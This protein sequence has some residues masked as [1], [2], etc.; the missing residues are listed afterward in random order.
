MVVLV[1]AA[2]AVFSGIAVGMTARWPTAGVVVSFVLVS[3]AAVIVA[4]HPSSRR[5]IDRCADRV[6]ALARRLFSTDSRA[7]LPDAVGVGSAEAHLRRADV[8]VDDESGEIPR[9][10]SDFERSWRRRILSMGHRE[11]DPAALA[12][13]LSIPEREIDL[14]WEAE[15]G[16]LVASVSNERAGQWP[17]RAAF[18]ADVTAVAEFRAKYPEW[19]TLDPPMRTR[20]LAALRLCLD[21]CP[22][23]DGDVTLSRFDADRFDTGR[24]RSAD[25]RPFLGDAAAR[26]GD[27]VL[28]ATCAGCDARLFEAEVDR[29]DFDASYQPDADAEA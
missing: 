27:S 24:R 22:T 2:F 17:S 25:G 14:R 7:Q 19:W 6:S 20:V 23:C 28:A 18:V 29:V 5:R 9:I 26:D 15:E 11:D 12:N 13:L 3:T 4:D 16:V 21:R 8:L 1:V 10:A